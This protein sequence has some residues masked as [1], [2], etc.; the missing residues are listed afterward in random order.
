MA[1]AEKK[2]KHVWS[3][4]ERHLLLIAFEEFEFDRDDV[5]K[6]FSLYHAGKFTEPQSPERIAD[7]YLSRKYNTR[8][9]MRAEHIDRAQDDE[10]DEAQRREARDMIK[11]AAALFEIKLEERKM[12]HPNAVRL[13][14]HQLGMSQSVGSLYSSSDP[15]E[16]GNVQIG[17]SAG[18]TLDVIVWMR[19][20]FD[21]RSIPLM[22]LDV[23]WRNTMPGA[24]MQIYEA[25]V[26]A[27]LFRQWGIE[28]SSG[29]ISVRGKSLTDDGRDGAETQ[30]KRNEVELRQ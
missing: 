10:E 6:I 7:E 15:V 1:D 27:G 26:A 5:A 16:S 9:L 23:H 2:R 22:Q 11:T 28:T 18:F 3:T 24:K 30:S 20:E 8:S 14:G 21:A 12:K 13:T 17:N 19:G 29:E 4:Q 25:M